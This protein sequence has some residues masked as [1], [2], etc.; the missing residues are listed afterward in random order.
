MKSLTKKIE[1]WAIDRNLHTADPKKQMLKVC[2]EFGE[3]CASLARGN[4]E[5][6]KDDIGDIYVTLVILSKQLGF[7]AD[8]EDVGLADI[9]DIDYLNSNLSSTIGDLYKNVHYGNR[10]NAF[11]HIRSAISLIEVIATEHFNVTFKDCVT[12]AYREIK[13]RKGKMIDGVFVKEEDLPRVEVSE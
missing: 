13:D 4:Q 2:E 3:L 5:S 7:V 8:Y 12:I 11:G 1:Q 9:D 6:A 10:Y